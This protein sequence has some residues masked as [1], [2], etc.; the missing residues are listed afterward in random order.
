VFVLPASPG[1]REPGLRT[2][3]YQAPANPSRSGKPVVAEGGYRLSTRCH[4]R[5]SQARPVRFN[6]EQMRVNILCQFP[7]AFANIQQSADE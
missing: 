1:M 4:P 7:G 6:L 2:A 3:F 5:S